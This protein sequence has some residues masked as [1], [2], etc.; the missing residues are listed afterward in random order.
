MSDESFSPDVDGF[1][2]ATRPTGT[3]AQPIREATS[4]TRGPRSRLPEQVLSAIARNMR[5]IEATTKLLQESQLTMSEAQR[6]RK[7]RP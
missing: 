4:E 5:R 3:R 1:D 2:S 6:A 7:E